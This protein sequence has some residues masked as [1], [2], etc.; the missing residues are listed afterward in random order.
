M[1]I[2]NIFGPI[3]NFLHRKPENSDLRP[4]SRRGQ[5]FPRVAVYCYREFIHCPIYTREF[6][7]VPP[8]IP[9]SPFSERSNLLPRNAFPMGRFFLFPAKDSLYSHLIDF[10]SEIPGGQACGRNHFL[11]PVYFTHLQFS[12]T[13]LSQ[14]ANLSFC[15]R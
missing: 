12:K 1:S 4:S 9:G 7:S 14:L 13:L 6:D 11:P 10:P 15:L 2:L 3:G 5:Y 8:L